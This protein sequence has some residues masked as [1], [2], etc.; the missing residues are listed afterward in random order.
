MRAKHKYS[1]IPT[2]VRGIRFASKK[3][4][5]RYQELLLMKAQGIVKDIELQPIYLL[6]EGFERN[7]KK[8]R[9]INYRADFRVTY[10]DGTVEV[11]DVKGYRTRE[12]DRTEKML[13]YRYP[14]LRFRVGGELV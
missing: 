10:F 4:A 8:H 7:G 12:F 3:E 2:E 9:P 11:E 13:L 5:K 1:A 6:Q 14:D